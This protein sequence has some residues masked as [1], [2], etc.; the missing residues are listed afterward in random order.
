MS[1]AKFKGKD[2]NIEVLV[3]IANWEAFLEG[4]HVF[5]QMCNSMDNG[6]H[7]EDC[8]LRFKVFACHDLAATYVLITRGQTEAFGQHFC[9]WCSATK[10]TSC[11]IA[12]LT[13]VLDGDTI[14]TVARNSRMSEMLSKVRIIPSI[15]K[16]IVIVSFDSMFGLAFTISNCLCAGM[17][18]NLYNDL[19]SIVFRT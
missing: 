10:G 17:C 15:F 8:L 16:D 18:S 12:I 14:R 13:L 1:L 3:H 5:Y 2:S 9:P 6:L 7:V 19:D 4:R 11:D